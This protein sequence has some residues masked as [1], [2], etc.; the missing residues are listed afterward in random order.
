MIIPKVGV[1]WVG[2]V[3]Q[4]VTMASRWQG[5][6]VKAI[7]YARAQTNNSGWQAVRAH[8]SGCLY[9]LVAADQGQAVDYGKSVAYLSIASA[10]NM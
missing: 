8:C 5:D 1:C 2:G 3:L 7:C 9:M 10:L 6:K 4:D